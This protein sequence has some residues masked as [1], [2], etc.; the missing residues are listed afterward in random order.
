MALQP[1]ATAIRRVQATPV[2]LR[3]ARRD[4]LGP[5]AI[6]TGDDQVSLIAALAMRIGNP[7]YSP[8]PSIRPQ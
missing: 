3:E 1:Q 6:G 4:E 5:G 7:S 8:P 2:P